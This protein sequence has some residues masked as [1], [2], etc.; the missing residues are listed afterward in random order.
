MKFLRIL[1]SLILFAPLIF[2]QPHKKKHKKQVSST[3]QNSQQDN[4][5]QELKDLLNGL[6]AYDDGSI[7]SELD[8]DSNV[9]TISNP[10]DDSTVIISVEDILCIPDTTAN[11][12]DFLYAERVANWFNN[13]TIP[14]TATIETVERH[15]FAQRVDQMIILYG[16]PSSFINNYGQEVENL[17]LSGTIITQDGRQLDG[18]FEYAQAENTKD[19]GKPTLYHRFLHP[20]SRTVPI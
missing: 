15:R 9:I 7:I 10:Y 16:R 14:L 4:T 5:H 3:T 6:I 13:A 12:L 8:L 19:S 11:Q 1:Y 20:N 2:A 18:I 17:T